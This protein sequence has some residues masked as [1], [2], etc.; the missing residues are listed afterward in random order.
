MKPQLGFLILSI[1]LLQGCAT[2]VRLP[3]STRQTP[4]TAGRLWGGHA[5]F[6]FASSV[7]V[8][9]IN[10]PTTT[11]P[12][13]TDIRVGS[14]ENLSGL[15]FPG[16]DLFSGSGYD[17]A[18]GVSSSIDLYFTANPG[19]KF[20]FMGPKREPKN[21]MT[22]GGT[23]GTSESGK[24]TGW[25]GSI[26]AGPF[27]ESTSGEDNG[28]KSNIGRSG[29]EAGIS[30]GNKFDEAQLFYFTFATRGGKADVAITQT[31][32]TKY[33]YADT[34]DQF[35]LSIGYLTGASWYFKIEASGSYVTWKGRSDSLAKDISGSGTR[36]GGVIGFGYNW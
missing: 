20:Q 24:N 36:L 4:M 29:L 7:P 5:G 8:T 26:F 15:L 19:I 27:S 1:L 9:I 11:P 28:S 33:S 34:Y 13:R 10:N 14:D 18:L 23:T 22:T 32:G 25:V 17:F 35:F 6:D 31:S 12:T 3:G 21:A 30:I 2:V 16:L